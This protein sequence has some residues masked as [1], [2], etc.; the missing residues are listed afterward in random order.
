MSESQSIFFI[1]AK[2]YGP[3]AKE[4]DALSA[5]LRQIENQMYDLH[6]RTFKFNRSTRSSTNNSLG[7]SSEAKNDPLRYSNEVK[8]DSLDYDGINNIIADINDE[9][10]RR[11]SQYITY[12]FHDTFSED[13]IREYI[14]KPLEDARWYVNLEKIEG[15]KYDEWS[16]KWTIVMIPQIT[17]LECDN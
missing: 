14:I 8:N 15:G 13:I 4:H 10:T 16:I 11:K 17:L 5:K 1:P 2:E 9:I 12:T 7:Y 3:L 6:A